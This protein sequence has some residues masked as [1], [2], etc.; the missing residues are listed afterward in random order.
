MDVVLGGFVDAPRAG[1]VRV[2]GACEPLAARELLVDFFSLDLLPSDAP[3]SLLLLPL[4]LAF[5][6]S[7]LLPELTPVAAAPAA[8]GMIAI[9]VDDQWCGESRGD[10]ERV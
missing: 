8:G 7:L 2:L 4:S 10:R 9:I 6:L 3:A 5:P 1:E